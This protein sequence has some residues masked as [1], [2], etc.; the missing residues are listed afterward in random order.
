MEKNIVQALEQEKKYLEQR[1]RG[2]K[3]RLRDFVK[4][5]GYDDVN[6]FYW[7]KQS[8]LFRHQPYIVEK[9]PYIDLSLSQQ[10]FLDKKPAL[11]YTINCSVNYV[12]VPQEFTDVN[13]LW[14]LG[15]TP[16]KLGYRY[17]DEVIISS[18][19]DLRI[20]LIYPKEINVT[21]EYILG[22]FRSELADIYDGVEMRGEDI[23]ISGKKVMGSAEFLKGDMKVFIAQVSYNDPSRL[24]EKIYGK[25][26]KP[27]GCVDAR[28]ISP[29]ELKDRFV[30]WLGI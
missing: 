10:Y 7:E 13:K 19:G 4:E 26:A 20:F 21:P 9:E 25:T 5:C 8:Y 28:F 23:L 18:D 6:D 2:E 17:K 3:V 14:N 29:Y 27:F 30:K 12:F 11:L 1:S 22:F 16:V 15:L 24:L